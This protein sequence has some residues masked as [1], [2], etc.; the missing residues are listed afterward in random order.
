MFHTLGEPVPDRNKG[1]LIGE[2]NHAFGGDTN[3]KICL[4]W[5]WTGTGFPL[6]SKSLGNGQWWALKE[7][8]GT[9]HDDSGWHASQQFLSES[10]KVLE[11]ALTTNGYLAGLQFESEYGFGIMSD[12][13]IVADALANLGAHLTKVKDYD[14]Q[15][16]NDTGVLGAGKRSNPPSLPD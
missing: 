14:E 9:Y 11:A 7:W 4:G 12:A 13:P 6:S 1:A 15:Q 8:I 5:I 16:R 2:M 10:I 3:R